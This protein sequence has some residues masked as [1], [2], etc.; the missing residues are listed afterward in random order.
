MN[1]KILRRTHNN[2]GAS[3]ER[4]VVA[5]RQPADNPNGLRQRL[6]EFVGDD[7]LL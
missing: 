6:L 2:L 4:V 1:I 5:S 7:E 3:A